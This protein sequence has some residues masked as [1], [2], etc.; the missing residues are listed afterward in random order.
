MKE[1]IEGIIVVEGK[2]D[3]ALLSTYFDAEFVI[4]NGSSIPE[5]TIKYLIKMSQIKDIYVLTDP[6]SPGKRIRD[7]LDSKIKNLKHCF[8]T[9]ENS[10]K[11]GKVGVA[12]G[13]INEIKEA[14]KHSFTLQD[15]PKGT[16]TTFDLINLGLSG[17]KDANNKRN[18]VSKKLNL[19][20][21]N[22]KTFLKRVNSAN[23]SYEEIKQLL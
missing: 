5:E 6:D 1:K 16:L 17:S 20:H 9:K 22:T 10:I 2:T 11:H 8:I 3:V 7:V 21:C 14:L 12:E 18:I 4:T 13:N 23:I 15:N 19:G